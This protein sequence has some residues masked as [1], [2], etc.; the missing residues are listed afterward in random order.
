MVRL[1][2]IPHQT[3]WLIAS[4]VLTRLVVGLGSGG[5]GDATIALEERMYDIMAEEIRV[6]ADRY[7]MPREHAADLVSTLGALSV[8][9]FGPDFETRFIEG[10]PEEGVIRLL[11][12]AMFREESAHGIP[13]EEVNRVCTSYVQHAIGALNPEFTV[14][15]TK[16]RCRDDGFCEMIIARK[17]AAVHNY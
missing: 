14:H 10:Y 17:G 5:E 9:L 8:I 4:H 12:C 6:L 3:R 7:A 11:A 1:K 13:P 2:E 16:A 15:I